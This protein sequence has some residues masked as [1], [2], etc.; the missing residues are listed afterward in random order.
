MN[1]FKAQKRLETRH[2]V[3]G[4]VDHEHFVYNTEFPK[5]F[6]YIV[7]TG[8]GG[9]Y[10]IHT[11]QQV[12]PGQFVMKDAVGEYPVNPVDF[13]RTYEITPGQGIKNQNQYYAARVRPSD[14][15]GEYEELLNT[16]HHIP[17]LHTAGD[18]RRVGGS[19]PINRDVF[20]KGHRAPP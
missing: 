14:Y 13:N 18:F 16:N 10:Q 4:P 5:G 12:T 8:Q 3:R 11:G 20:L 7:P 2:F 1:S 19:Y 15:V 17:P 9:S 6:S